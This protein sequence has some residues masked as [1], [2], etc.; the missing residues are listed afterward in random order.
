MA[1]YLITGLS[2][3]DTPPASTI[4]NVEQPGRP[5]WRDIYERIRRDSTEYNDSLITCRRTTALG[6]PTATT[7]FEA[8][9]GPLVV[10]MQ[11]LEEKAKSFARVEQQ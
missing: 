5:S 6:M 11:L 2:I 8:E 9:I 10:Q 7:P 3:A 4:P 1:R